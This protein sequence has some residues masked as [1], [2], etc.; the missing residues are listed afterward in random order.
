MPEQMGEP[1]P[2]K[3]WVEDLKGWKPELDPRF[4]RDFPHIIQKLQ[5]ADKWDYELSHPEWF[6]AVAPAPAKEAIPTDN[7]MG[8]DQF[9]TFKDVEKAKQRKS[10][11]DV[12]SPFAK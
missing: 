7:S 3:R 11:K 2:E 1:V 9:Q 12:K 5:E 8:S 4:Q 6:P 10:F